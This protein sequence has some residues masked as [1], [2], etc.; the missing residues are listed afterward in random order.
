MQYHKNAILQKEIAIQL[1]EIACNILDIN[2]RNTIADIGC[3]SGFV[4]EKLLEIGM[5]QDR[6]T[7]F[8]KNCEKLNFASQFG[9]TQIWDFNTQF[10]GTQKFD[11]IF[12]SMALQWAFNFNKTLATI[13]NM[14]EVGGQFFFATPVNNSLVEVYQTL[15][16][17]FMVFPKEEAIN[18]QIV[19]KIEFKENAYEALKSIH[20]LGLKVG[21]QK[22]TKE[23]VR[24]LK[25][26]ETAWEIGIFKL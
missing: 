25:S 7:Q 6:I 9:K 24:S 4:A 11:I 2:S 21:Q 15:G 14:L 20:T 3:G 8:D 5:M 13:Q 1:V 12:S 17:R 26:T 22:I 19:K 10:Y 16:T 23:M 18:A